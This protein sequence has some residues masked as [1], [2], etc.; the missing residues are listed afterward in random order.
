VVVRA[1]QSADPVV[2]SQLSG[3][4]GGAAARRWSVSAERLVVVAPGSVAVDPAHVVALH[5]VSEDATAI[6]LDCGSRLHACLPLEVVHAALLCGP[7]SASVTKGERVDGGR[8]STRYSER[9]AEDGV[10]PGRGGS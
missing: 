9:S 2:A 4:P 7:G 3:L 5:A 10:A 6:I 1:L 8:D